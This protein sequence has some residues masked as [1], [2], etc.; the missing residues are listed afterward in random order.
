MVSYHVKLELGCGG[1]HEYRPSNLEFAAAVGDAL[2]MVAC[3]GSDNSSFALLW[4]E[5]AEGGGCTSEFEAS[6][7]LQILSF[8]INVGL[9]LFG[10]V[11]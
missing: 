4:V 11:C 10:E 1:W 5:V 7:G 6:Y 8:K 9:V 3:A 2:C